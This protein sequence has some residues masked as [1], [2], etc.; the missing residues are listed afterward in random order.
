MKGVKNSDKGVGRN[1]GRKVWREKGGHR[2]KGR[3]HGAYERE[4]VEGK[5]EGEG[6]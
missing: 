3:M 6:E 1:G 5:V 2:R 4:G